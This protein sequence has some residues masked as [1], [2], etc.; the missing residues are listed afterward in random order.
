[1]ECR[2]LERSGEAMAVTDDIISSETLRK[3]IFASTVSTDKSQIVENYQGECF[4][5]VEG[6]PNHA[7]EAARLTA[8]TAIW[9]YKVVRLRPFYWGDKRGLLRRIFRS[10]NIAVWQKQREPGFSDGLSAS[11]AMAIVGPYK[12]WWAN[13]GDT[14]IFLFRDGK[15]IKL[16]KADVNKSG[17]LTKAIGKERYG[18]VPQLKAENWLTSDIILLANSRTVNSLVESEVIEILAKTGNTERDLEKALAELV[19]LA[20][21][22]DNSRAA[23]FTIIKRVALNT[24]SIQ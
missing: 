15:L 2:E 14:A 22:K 10:T 7:N 1:M 9:G 3:T 16:S 8:D 6:K 19:V 13:V 12:F 11:M 17:S 18:L 23:F 5:L 24:I 21:K 20:Q 4:A